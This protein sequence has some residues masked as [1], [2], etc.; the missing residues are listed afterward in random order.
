MKAAED[1]AEVCREIEDYEGMPSDELNVMEALEKRF[2]LANAHL[3]SSIDRRKAFIAE[4]KS[5][6]EQGREVK[7]NIDKVLKRLNRLETSLKAMTLYA[8]HQMP[9]QPFRDS[10][11]R[12]LSLQKS[13]PVVKVDEGLELASLPEQY[14]KS[15]LVYSIDKEALKADLELGVEIPWARLERTEYVRGL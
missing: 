14:L 7:K 13:P 12:K 3:E 5:K 11:G 9:N 8:M 4:L 6:V 10:M 2:D 1:L 15:E